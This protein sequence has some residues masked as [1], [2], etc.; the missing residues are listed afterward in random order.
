[1]NLLFCIVNRVLNHFWLF[2]FLVLMIGP[3]VLCV[4]GKHS[5][6]K[7]PEV[8]FSLVLVYYHPAQPGL[9]GA[10]HLSQPSRS[11]GYRHTLSNL[12]IFNSDLSYLSTVDYVFKTKAQKAMKPSIWYCKIQLSQICRNTFA[13]ESEI[14]LGSSFQMILHSLSIHWCWQQQLPLFLE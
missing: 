6:T 3:R 14:Q 10:I 2:S 1:M 8:L 13:P 7:L 4:Q 9:T 12:A 11:W 5:T